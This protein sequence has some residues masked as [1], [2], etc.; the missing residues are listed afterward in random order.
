MLFGILNEKKEL[1]FGILNEKKEVVPVRSMLEWA[2]W[3]VS[4]TEEGRADKRRVAKTSL[5]GHCIS[6]VFLGIDHG[7]LTGP[8]WFETMVFPEGEKPI[9]P[10][11]GGKLREYLSEIQLRYATYAEAEKGHQTVVEMIRRGLF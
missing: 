7:F 5:N 4:S 8:L 2:D 11:L 3:L 6:T 10:E 9:V 1:S